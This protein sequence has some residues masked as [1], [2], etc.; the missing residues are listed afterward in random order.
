[1]A[2]EYPNRSAVWFQRVVWVGIAANFALAIPTFLAPE[3]MIEFSS[4]PPATPLLWVRFSALLLMLLSLF[5]IP[6]ARDCIRY[7]PV[8]VLTVLSR[9]A[10]VLFFA[11]QP[12][13]YRQFGLFDLVF[14]IPEGILLLLVSRSAVPSTT[15]MNR[16]RV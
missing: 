6:A 14:L 10:G 8:A 1:M 13:A 7:R 5:Y 3:R 4:V 16:Q 9:L 11:T 2:T 12:A 15:A